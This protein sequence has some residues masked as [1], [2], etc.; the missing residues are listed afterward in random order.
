[1]SDRAKAL[2]PV[3]YRI[4]TRKIRAARPGWSS[5]D[6]DV[7]ARFALWNAWG[8]SNWG[9]GWGGAG[10]GSNNMGA[11]QACKPT[12]ERCNCAQPSFIYVDSRPDGSKYRY[13]YRVYSSPEAGLL[14]MLEVLY[15]GGRATS[16]KT[17]DGVRVSMREALSRQYDAGYY[18]GFGPD[19]ASRIASRVKFMENAKNASN[20]YLPKYECGFSCKVKEF[21]KAVGLWQ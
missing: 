7:A 5:A 3:L 14:D 11:I 6:V 19:R 4:A 15:F 12:G 1:M 17:L 20:R 16:A 13:C 21:L 9:A 18:E 2:G 10:V 8:E